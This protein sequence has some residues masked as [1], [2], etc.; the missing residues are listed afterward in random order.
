MREARP[1]A[2]AARLAVRSREPVEP[3]AA[4]SHGATWALRDSRSGGLDF[5]AAWEGRPSSASVYV[6]AA[7]A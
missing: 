6:R 2:D 5:I 1:L 3:L 4:E 7:S